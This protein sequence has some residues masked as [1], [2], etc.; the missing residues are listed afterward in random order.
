MD[1]L[2]KD[3]FISYG[4]RE[5]L[6]FVA[7]LHR[8]LVLSGHTAWFDKVNIPDGEAYDRRITNGIESADNFVS[9]MA[10]RCLTSPYCLV[11]L[12]YARVLGKRIIPINQ[13]VIFKTDAQ[14]LSKG[15]QAVLANFY[16]T[17][18][19]PDAGIRTT[20]DVLDRTLALIGTT[21]WLD[22]KQIL[23][24]NDCLRLQEWAQSYENQW[25]RHEDTA[26]LSDLRMPTFGQITDQIPEI[27][28]RMLL[29]I[30]R[31]KTYVQEHTRITLDALHWA[32]NQK[33]TNYLAVGKERKQAEDW[34]LTEFTPPKQPPCTPSDILCDFV[35]ESR[36]NAE[37]RHTDIFI[38]YA[39][40]DKAIRDQVIRA[41]SRHA[42]TTWIH[43]K[44]I[45]KGAEYGRAIEQGIEGAD[46]FFFFVSPQSVKSEYCLK[47]LNHAILYHKRLVPLLIHS[48]PEADIPEALRGL[49]YIDFTDN[50][51]ESDFA[52]DL[53]DI[54]NLLHQD[55]EYY[56]EHKILLNR[57]LRWQESGR[58]NAFLLRGFNLENAKTWLRLHEKRQ[59]N[60]PLDIHRQLIE[61][62]EALKGQLGTDVFVSY[63]RKDGDFARKLNTRLQEAG[64]TTWFD[65]ESISSGVDFEKEIY[66]GID[67]ADNI[68]FLISPDS[69]ASEYCER[70]VAYAAQLGKRFI[71]LLCRPT[72]PQM[73]P[74]VLRVINWIDFHSKAFDKVFP[75]LIQELDLDR[76]HVQQH[77]KLQ[78][79]ALEWAE[80]DHSPDF[81][82]N[83][84][85]CQKA[86]LWRTAATEGKPKNPPPTALQQ[87]YIQQSLE[88]IEQAK[89]Q[90]R[91]VAR[92][93]KKRLRLAR[94]ALGVA[95]L[96][97][98]VAGFATTQA[99]MSEKKAAFALQQA[100]EAEEKAHQN[101]IY[102]MAALD[103]VRQI[104]IDKK[105]KLAENY[106][107]FGEKE[108]AQQALED[109]LRLDPNN[110]DAQQKQKSL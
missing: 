32:S 25:H 4:R 51:T 8:A 82:L 39:A 99:L 58:K 3:C 26:Y 104:E 86:Q 19:M 75:E 65:Q 31:Q 103:S 23:S 20:Q 37:N 95:A 105:L 85:A 27:L 70:E 55:H 71:T 59:Q 21:D 98:L 68:V 54:L 76:E 50:T 72:D 15:D 43:D 88:A 53:D 13:M 46:N 61:T 77:T 81:L 84:M 35:V 45:Q 90:E 36:K 41:L 62:S 14:E 63:S 6:S 80:N 74:E 49:Q 64:K 28:E 56:E 42:L 48:T 102:A 73:M 78:Q 106:I 33:S 38:C 108:L 92:S 34:L 91:A 18:G 30:E 79:R 5:S 96:L 16:A 44:D 47:E 11:E 57:A 66:K 110:T 60:P 109:V 107:N 17:H 40:E 22:G 52:A 100:L 94:I 1:H 93:L 69:I 7:H 101:E 24:D 87:Q 29:V 67:G 12:E 83:D 97:L 9:V 10:P 89:A 2:T